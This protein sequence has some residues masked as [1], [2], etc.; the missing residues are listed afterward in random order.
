LKLLLDANLSYK[1]VAR[2]S[3]LFPGSLHV[4]HTELEKGNDRQVWEFA[5]EHGFVIVSK[6]S[7]PPPREQ[8]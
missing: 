7:V 2:L 5:L 3:D 1:L 4:S 8:P 6:D